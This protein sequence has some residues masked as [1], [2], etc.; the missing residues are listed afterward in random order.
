MAKFMRYFSTEEIDK[1]K[2]SVAEEKAKG[3]AEGEQALKDRDAFI[4]RLPKKAQ[5]VTR[6]LSDAGIVFS[7]LPFYATKEKDVLSA[8]IK[9]AGDNAAKKSRYTK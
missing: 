3:A 7:A 1:R 8:R 2:K 9:Q 4:A 5:R 6:V